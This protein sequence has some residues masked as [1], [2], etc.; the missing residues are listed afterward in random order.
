M[1]LI[2]FSCMSFHYLKQ[3]E[4]Q[5]ASQGV[6]P[7]HPLMPKSCSLLSTKGL[8]LP[9]SALRSNAS[10]ITS[11]ALLLSVATVVWYLSTI[12]EQ[13]SVEKRLLDLGTLWT[14]LWNSSRGSLQSE[15]ACS[16]DCIHPNPTMIT[17][18]WLPASDHPY[19]PP[20]L[21]YKPGDH[22]IK[23]SIMLGRQI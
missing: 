10:S 7:V 15:T 21:P 19:Y 2:A 11:L 14:P 4:V 23:R 17:S 16:L 6:P 22:T 18:P 5:R 3:T 20:Q 1:T 12:R 8:S 9:P 13:C